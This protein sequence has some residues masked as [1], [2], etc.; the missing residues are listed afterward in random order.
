LFDRQRIPIATATGLDATF[1]DVSEKSSSGDFTIASIIAPGYAAAEQ[2]KGRTEHR[3]LT[4]SVRDL[5]AD[6]CKGRVTG[7]FT[8]TPGTPTGTHMILDGVNIG[9]LGKDVRARMRNASGIVTGDVRINGIEGDAKMMTGQGSLVLRSG[10]CTEIELVRQIGEVLKYAAL[11]GFEVREAR[12]DFRIASGRVFLSPL[13]VSLH[14]LGIA[15]T[16]TVAFDG[17]V[18]L[19]GT[20]S[21]PASIVQRTGL[22]SGQFSPPDASGRQSVNFDVTGTLDKPKQN[23]AAQL[24]GTKDRTMQRIIA[25]ESILSTLFGRKVD[26]AKPG[27]PAPAAPAQRQP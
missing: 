13:D 10:R 21:A 22:V 5:A 7:E 27:S 18:E 4:F 20:L 23:L 6:V 17:A 3:D 24:T 25:A 1:R 2:I 8:F 12:A 19:I 26:K 14:P 9:L 11:A 15:A 16:G